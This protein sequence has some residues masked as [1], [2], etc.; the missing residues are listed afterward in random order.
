MFQSSWDF[1]LWS[2][3]TFTPRWSSRWKLRTKWRQLR[4]PPR[5]RRWPSSKWHII[6][7]GC[8]WDTS[9]YIMMDIR[10]DLGPI[11]VW[12]IADRFVEDLDRD[13]YDIWTLAFL[14]RW[15]EQGLGHHVS[16]C[17]SCLEFQNCQ[18]HGNVRSLKP[19]QLRCW[20]MRVSINEGTP[21]TNGL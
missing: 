7:S 9:W 1:D 8:R 10:M 5:T 18:L 21:K 17:H 13:N 12:R 3:A 19:C 20:D 16:T 2:P 14:E 15:K 4:R 11:S 6:G